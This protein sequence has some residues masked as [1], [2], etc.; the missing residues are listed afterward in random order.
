MNPLIIEIENQ[1]TV[2][3]KVAFDMAR[4]LL[5]FNS[6]IKSNNIKYKINMLNNDRRDLL[7]LIDKLKYI[8]HERN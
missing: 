6:V 8:S 7:R 1:I 4:F 5:T 3:D 2:L